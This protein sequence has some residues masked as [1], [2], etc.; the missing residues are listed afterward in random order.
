M[1]RRLHSIPGLLAALVV[2]FMAIT[3]AV[4]SLQ[5]LVERVFAPAGNE[6]SVATL[7]DRVLAH[8][9]QTES[10]VRSASGAVT[11]YVANLSIEIDPATGASLG[12]VEHSALFTFFT[13]LHRSL[14]LGDG[15]RVVAG[16]AAV[17][18]VILATSGI[19][20][21][22]NRMGGWKQ[23][24]ATAR[25]TLS[26]R[27]HVELARLA[28]ICLLLSAITGVYMTL[29]TF[30]IV[31]DGGQGFGFPPYGSGETPAPI[32]S[33]SALQDV[34]ISDLRSIILPMADDPQDVFTVTTSAGTGYVDQASG[35]LLDFTP[36]A[37]M[38]TL[39]EA[40][41][42]LHTGQGYWWLGVLLGLAS[43]AVPVLMITGTLIW[44]RRRTSMPRMPG[45]AGWRK[46]DTVILVGSESNTTWSFAAT[47][48]TALAKNG[49]AV[50]VAPMN[51]LR[52]SYPS[53]SRV[54]V[55]AA[56]YG[57]G[58]APANANRFIERLARFQGTGID[59]AVLG[60]GDR[61]F[62]H[63]CAY[64]ET[65][66]HAM[67]A[68]GLKPITGFEPID[69]QSAQ[70]FGQWGRRLGAAMG[71]TLELLHQPT[72]PKTQSYK[73]IERHDYG[74]EVQAPTVLL[75]F[76]IPAAPSWTQALKSRLGLDGFFAGDLAGIMP[77]TDPIPRYYSIASRSADGILE[78]CVRKLQGGV[79]SD[80][81]F[82]LRPGDSVEA[83]VRP[84]PDFRPDTGSQPLILIGAGAGVAPLV[85]FVRANS[86]HRPVYLFSG[87][88]DPSSDFLYREELQAQLDAGRLTRL[89]AVFSRVM[90]G[91]Y[92]QHRLLDEA[93]Q[94]RSLVRQGA[95]FMV[96][97]SAAMGDGVRAS[98]DNVLAPLD[99]S[100]ERLQSAGRYAEDVY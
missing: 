23:L 88:R 75:R 14:F 98:L 62:R 71:E 83:F 22:I 97:G 53:A 76:A 93:E 78:I 89:F 2:S 33:L 6:M 54:M 100:V 34:P 7:V 58:T 66:E 82:G 21:L 42:T 30:G 49:H 59:Y 87:G 80:Y 16:V 65:V 45:D 27:L 15:G 36:N 92:V 91:R 50:H 32:A 9:P 96:C 67:A 56:T 17:A 1:L 99:L 74:I 94:L 61:K 46:A 79:C 52:A 72:Q 57:N 70:A 86:R 10:V 64:A 90:G 35:A 39:Y 19:A 25:G 12:P 5:P 48:R 47:L 85:G 13:E 63:F 44:L 77:P 84:N 20:L 43:L 40:I 29:V 60:F 51:C 68:H 38:Q 26:Q 18:M 3:G 55:L 28:V 37:P 31:S 95:R 24:F 11:A 69:R 41:Y 8:Q 81:L 4:L 73:L